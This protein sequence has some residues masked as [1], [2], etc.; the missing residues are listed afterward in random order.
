MNCFIIR[1]VMIVAIYYTLLFFFFL[2]LLLLLY[3]N[4][5]VCLLEF[6]SS[7]LDNCHLIPDV[8]LMYGPPNQ[9]I[10]RELTTH[11]KTL[12]AVVNKNNWQ[13]EAPAQSHNIISF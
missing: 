11:R 9:R 7:F 8:C 10:Q 4:L 13:T 1:N 5:N 6:L 2:S 12:W 3:H